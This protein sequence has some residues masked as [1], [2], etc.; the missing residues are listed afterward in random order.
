MNNKDFYITTTEEPNIVKIQLLERGAGKIKH[1]QEANGRLL[2]QIHGLKEC[3]ADIEKECED[4]KII[5]LKQQGIATERHF[6]IEELKRKLNS[7]YGTHSKQLETETAKRIFNS[8]KG[9]STVRQGFMNNRVIVEFDLE[10]LKEIEER[11]T[12][13]SK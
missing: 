3:L 1:L 2:E 11:Y 4:L 13:D 7:I 9:I 12:G 5:A 8:L 6:K 10:S